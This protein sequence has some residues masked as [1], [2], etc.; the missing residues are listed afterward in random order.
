MRVLG[1][2]PGLERCGVAVLERS[3][4]RTR[5]VSFGTITTGSGPVATRLV[6][7]AAKLRSVIREHQPEVAAIEQLFVNRNLRTAMTV[8]QASG[9]ALLVVAEAYPAL[10]ANQ[11]FRFR[12]VR[13][14]ST[15]WPDAAVE[16]ELHYELEVPR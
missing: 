6:E 12:F 5:A 8:G 10:R 13:R 15:V 2:D 14:E 4:R 7:L 9:V 3:G 11:A 1:I 16:D